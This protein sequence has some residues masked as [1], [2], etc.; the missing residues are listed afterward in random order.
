VAPE[1][2]AS[3]AAVRDERRARAL[4]HFAGVGIVGAVDEKAVRRDEGHEPPERRLHRRE[5]GKHLGV[6]V[7]DGGQ[8][9]APRPVVQELR[10]LV[11]E[12]GLVLVP[13]DDEILPPP[14]PKDRSKFFSTPPTRNDGSRPADV[15]VH[16]MSPAVVVLPCVPATTIGCRPSRNSLPIAC[17]MLAYGMPRSRSPPPPRGSLGSRCADDHESGR[18]VEMV[19]PVPLE[20]ADP[21]DAKHRAHGR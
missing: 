8:N 3:P 5:I 15:S 14:E 13:L 4:C 9:Y 16:A 10:A 11:E 1:P 2:L 12:R 6:V 7:L 21:F 19:R 20:D 17:G 18:F